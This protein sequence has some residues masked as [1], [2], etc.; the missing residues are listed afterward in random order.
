M[1]GKILSIERADIY[2][3]LRGEKEM[4]Q[5]EITWTCEGVDLFR[6]RDGEIVEVACVHPRHGVVNQ[7]WSAVAERIRRAVPDAGPCPNCGGGG[8]LGVDSAQARYQI[9]MGWAFGRYRGIEIPRERK[10]KDEDQ[11]QMRAGE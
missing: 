8:W 11:F 5:G 10:G 7:E 6:S 9:L 3:Y 4:P 1:A 2:P